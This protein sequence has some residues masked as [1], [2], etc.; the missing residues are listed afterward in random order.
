VNL[1]DCYAQG[2][3]GQR[4]GVY[5][6]VYTDEGSNMARKK[7]VYRVPADVTKPLRYWEAYVELKPRDGKRRRIPVRNKSQAK[8]LEELRET[9]ERLREQGDLPT[10]NPTVAQWFPLWLENVAAKE[11]A[12]KTYAGYRTVVFKHIIPTIGH[13]KMK[14]IDYET[15]REVEK[16]MLEK[17]LSSTYALN[18][19]RIM[20]TAFTTAEREGIMPKNFAK[21]GKA[22]RR[23]SKEL[24]VL[25]LDEGITMVEVMSREEFAGIGSRWVTSLLTGARRGEVI[26]LEVDRVG[27]VLDLSWQLQRLPLTGEYGVPKV[28]ADFEYRHLVDGLYLT[29]PKSK[30]G[31]RLIPLVDPLKSILE[32]HIAQMEPNPWGLL[33][34]VRGRPIDPDQDSKAWHGVLDAIGVTKNVRLHDVRHTTADMLYEAG[35]PEDLIMD[36]LGHST[37]A[38]SRAYK[39]RNNQKRLAEAMKQ[40]SAPFIS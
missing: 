6:N 38:M 40:L 36:I 17:G 18:A 19:H 28:R 5:T 37:R 30:K 27:E 10:A 13:V 4:S 12:P 34:T 24:E 33:W 3:T 22:P 23:K 16:A 21:L 29:R 14:N 7:E 11:I 15:V 20:S 25:T 1:D 8:A 32:R 26:G 39:S 35:V 9:R 2:C 31:W